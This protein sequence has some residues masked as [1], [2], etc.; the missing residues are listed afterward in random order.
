M[1]FPKN[2]VNATPNANSFLLA[3]AVPT[4]SRA[5]LFVLVVVLKPGSTNP[6]VQ[7]FQS[8]G[9]DPMGYSI[10]TANSLRSLAEFA[11]R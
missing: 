10:P 4:G 5:L 2:I 1:H 7:S 9:S 11:D 3:V 8:L 6:L